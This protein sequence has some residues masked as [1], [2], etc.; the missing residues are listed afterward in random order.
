MAK[1]RILYTS[2]SGD[3]WSLVKDA[4]DDR[5]AVRH[6][7]NPA[8]GGHASLIDIGVFLTRDARGPEHQALLRL[9]GTLLED[10]SEQPAAPPGEAGD[11]AGGGTAPFS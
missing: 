3:R 7:P 4:T 1:A 5:P 9:I 6:D 11:S 8:S 2:S 10:P